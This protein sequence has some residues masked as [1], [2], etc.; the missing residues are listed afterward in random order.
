[1]AIKPKILLDNT[2]E[3]QYSAKKE[4]TDRNYYRNK[5]FE[6]INNIKLEKKSDNIRYHVMNFYGI[7]GIGKSSL[8]QELC[9]E[10]NCDSDI[11]YAQIDFANSYN[12]SVSNLLLELAKKF[13][14]RKISLYH[15]GLAYAIYFEK[16]HKD[17]I[18]S[19]NTCNIIN[20]NLGFVAEILGTIEGLGILGIVP[21][22]INKIYNAAY[23]I[24]HLDPQLKG[25]LKEMEY[26]SALQCEQLLPAFFAYDLNKYLKKENDKIIIIFLDTYE[27]LCGQIK[28]DI[29]KFSQ[30]QFVRE[31]ISQLPGVLFVISGREFLEWEQIDPDWN[32][33]LEQ[34]RMERLE[35]GDAN[36]FLNNCG[37]KED[38]IRKKMISISMGHPYHLDILV[39]T[40][41]EMK[42]K[43]IIPTADLFANNAR[44]ILKCFFKYLQIEE[45]AVIK[46]ISIPRYYTLDIFNHLLLNFPTGYPITLFDEFNK[47][48]FVSKMDNGTYHIHEIM[49]KDLLEIIPKQLYEK[50]NK[51]VAEY[52]YIFFS[53]SSIYNERK[54]AVKECVYHLKFCLEQQ[55]YVEFLMSSFFDYF[56]DLQ[57]RGES[58]FLYDILI[59]IFSY[60][61]YSDC[62]ELYEIF[63]DMIMLIGNFKEAVEN[64]DSFL[65]NY[66][67]KQI[68]STEKI[69]QLYVKKIKHQMVYIS[70]NDTIY[71]INNIKPF[72]YKTNFNHQYL[73]LLYTEGNMLF[74]KGKFEEC[75]ICFDNVLD[76]SKQNHFADLK[77]RALRKKADY[78]LVINE[79]YKAEELCHVGLDIASQNQLNRY[80]NYLECTQAEIYRKLKLFE[81][82]KELYISCQKKFSELGIQPWIA[83]TEL[84]LAMIELEQENY[85]LVNEHL[86]IAKKIY[87]QHCHT[88]GIIHTQ[89]V[90][91]QSEFLQKG[92]FPQKIYN[93]LYHK[94]KK[95]GYDYVLEI[96]EKLE[97]GECFTTSLMF[98]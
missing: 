61:T 4:F 87:T 69:L 5:F 51:S 3:K 45:I 88:W 67:I 72:I 39:D 16:T 80:G 19:S 90:W 10:I 55:E 63:T 36:L 35:D 76:L 21:D 25:N 54:L 24:L 11:I 93:E 56:V 27:A 20:E 83:H 6:K 82:S 66:T 48:S 47:F 7:G 64:I 1:M 23:N 68:T 85:S 86:N 44:E 52:Y 74:E 50:V 75:K 58:A 18:F 22:A 94:C 9:R 70:L 95:Y 84:G 13:E 91:I 49:R 71:A 31:L 38:D 12:H 97:H 65:K 62:I 79:V 81:Q 34:Y 57:Y 17:M 77:C 26:K 60:I 53:N 96:L 41:V 46:I 30:D 43:N 14:N 8:Q 28:N 33:Y 37:I 40:Y 89:L 59:D 98:L 15:F 73:E 29:T 78:Y 2:A 92:V 42:N 32:N